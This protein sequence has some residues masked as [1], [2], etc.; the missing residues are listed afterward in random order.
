MCEHANPAVLPAQEQ[1]YLGIELGS[2]RVKAVLVGPDCRPLASGSAEWA[3][4]LKDGYWTYSL[5][6]VW[7]TLQACYAALA[8]QV[9]TIYGAQL[10]TLGGI[11]ISAMMH[12][13]LA[14]GEDGR[15]LVPFRTWQNTTT[16]P[17]ADELSGL[18]GC[19]I[20]Q[21]WS[22]AHVY[23]AMLN[24]EAHVPHI[25]R[26]NTLA[27][28]VHEQLTGEFVLGIGDASGMF[29][30][31]R[32]GYD[33][34]KLAAFDAAAG[35]FG[36]PWKL[37]DIL[38]PVRLAGE[39]AGRLTARGAALLDASGTLRP[40][41]PLCPPEGDAGTGMVATNSIA[42]RTG[43]VSAGTSIFSMVVLEHALRGVYPQIDIVATPEGAPAAMVHCNNCTGEIDAWAAVFMEFAEKAGFAMRKAACY[44]LLYRVAL[45]AD[46]PP[47]ACV[48]YN[49][50]A[51]EPVA[52]MEQGRPLLVRMPGMR[53]GLAGFMRAQ[54]YTAC[55][56]LRLGM[57]ILTQREHVEMQCLT[58]H[59]GFFKT[60]GAGQKVMADALGVPVAV[61]AT[62]GEGG[63]WGMAILAAYMANRGHFCGL[64]QFLTDVAFQGSE[65]RVETPTAAGQKD[66]EQYLEAW[67][68][69]MEVERA[70]VQHSAAERRKKLT[71]VGDR[72]GVRQS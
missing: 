7:H 47:Q 4:S 23:Q 26:L 40:G 36:V 8:A 59:G 37:R 54:L 33:K 35:R 31:G 66:F 45:E 69:G 55:A 15:L 58:G 71:D 13:Y 19:N 44:D 61:Q 67:K 53:W 22:A 3:S 12:G 17:A 72:E 32:A 46:G 10:Q 29:P 62:A 57:D 52:G 65:K 49:Y 11:G 51:G 41:I 68:N 50:L 43:N 42:P 64:Q 2:T 18:L 27:G 38:P 9:R 56:T 70:A 24:G 34:E 63:P 1:L 20:P 25:A 39:N 6:A 48:A 5:D 21:R 60:P 28:Y 30:V 16:G 14:F